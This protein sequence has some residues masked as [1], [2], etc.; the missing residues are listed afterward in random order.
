MNAT[1]AAP[2]GLCARLQAACQPAWTRYVRHPF[3]Q[4]LGEGT[5]AP[6]AFRHYLTQDYLFL[7]HYARAWALAT[8]K[9][10]G[11]DEMRRMN[12]HVKAVLDI[13]MGLHVAFCRDW[14]IDEATMASVAE[15]EATLGYTRYVLARGLDGDVLDLVVALAPCALGYAEIGQTLAAQATPDNPYAAWIEMY[16]GAEFAGVARSVADEI[17]RL[18]EARGGAA[19]FADLATTFEQAC[20]LE[21][22]FW[23]QGLAHGA[24]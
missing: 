18:G 19:R 24:T 3:V 23:R 6:A 8:A 16:A 7:V 11:L 22:D 20:R 17:D 14:G 4:Q 21:A 9:S 1:L 5:L 15:G 12:A 10:R 13:E 2:G